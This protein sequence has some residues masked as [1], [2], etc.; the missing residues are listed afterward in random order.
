MAIDRAEFEAL[1]ARHRNDP[2]AF[3]QAML[4]LVGPKYEALMADTPARWRTEAD[5]LAGPFPGPIPVDLA[6]DF[7]PEALTFT[8]E[9]ER[10]LDD[11]EMKVLEAW[12][13]AAVASPESID[14]LDAVTFASAVTTGTMPSSGAPTVSCWFDAI[15][16]GPATIRGLIDGISQVCVDAGLP[17]IRLWVGHQ[18][19][20]SPS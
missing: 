17:V 12:I 14:E 6:H 4:G 20:V 5:L 1:F 10:R 3:A 7:G 8:L 13:N 19:P 2:A 16:A 18:D 15:Q 11:D 9:L